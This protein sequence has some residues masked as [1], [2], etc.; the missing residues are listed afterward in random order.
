MPSPCSNQSCSSRRNPRR[1]P[2]DPPAQGTP[3]CARHPCMC[4]APLHVRG[5]PAWYMWWQG[6]WQGIKDSRR[7]LH[8]QQYCVSLART[9]FGL[10]RHATSTNSD[11]LMLHGCALMLYGYCMRCCGAMLECLVLFFDI[12]G[13]HCQIWLIS[14]KLIPAVHQHPTML[15]I[16]V[17][18]CFRVLT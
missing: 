2:Q 1:G 9:H 15:H 13:Y 16:W 10:R 5:T 8:L 17:K 3:A 7:D 14:I 18:W 11:V 4:E 12:C 6:W